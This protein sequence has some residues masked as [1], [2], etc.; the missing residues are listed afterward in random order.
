MGTAAASG[1]QPLVARTLADARDPQAAL[2]MLMKTAGLTP[3]ERE[4]AWQV[5]I[6]LAFPKAAADRK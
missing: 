1:L 3:R 2:D 5:A 6:G 4:V